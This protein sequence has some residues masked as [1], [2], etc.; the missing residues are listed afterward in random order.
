[1]TV[2]RISQTEPD[3]HNA[4]VEVV[5]GVDTHRDVHVAAVLTALGALLATAAFPTTAVGYRQ[6][7]AWARGF[8]V[9]HQAGVECTG[10]YGAA[11]TRAL[12][13]EGIQVVEVNQPDRGNRRRKGKTDTI[14]AEAAAR[15]VITGRATAIAKT[16]D[17][18]VEAMRL[19]KLA[20]DS[21]I[22]AST[23][24]INQLKSVLV[25][26]NPQLRE[27]LTGLG[28]MTLI[29]HCAQLPDVDP[30]AAPADQAAV[31]TL[32]ILARRVLTLK[33]EAY[34]LEKRIRT[35]IR[36]Q[37]PALLERV[38]VGP[39]SAAALL[40][41]AGDNPDRVQAEASYAALCGVSPVEASSGNTQR[42]RLNRG[43][44]R[45]ANA[46]LYRIVQSRLRFDERTQQYLQ[47][48]L[49][50]GKTRK[51]TIRCLKRYV[52]REIFSLLHP[53]PTTQS[54]AMAT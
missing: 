3:R 53:G 29:R 24:A 7:L 46:A 11:L 10:S 38:G 1:V 22:N 42:R 16:S 27:T 15:A 12:H 18:P 35:Q 43:G 14:D 50:E 4:D 33:A 23:K 45:Q 30:A 39:D 52:A 51:E 31:Y 6:L 17:G 47:R 34:E 8:G 19:L 37:A 2:T 20:R 25:G 41:T 5:L 28:P 49:Q 13:A 32:Q 44:D 36:A 26:A 9:L 54:N 40:I 48:R 21:A